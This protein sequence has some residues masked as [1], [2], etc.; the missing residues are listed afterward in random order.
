MENKITLKRKISQNVACLKYIINHKKK[1]FKTAW[2]RKQYIH[3]FTHDWDKLLPWRFVG[4]RRNFYPYTEKPSYEDSRAMIKQWQK[5]YR[6]NKHHW[7][8]W[9]VFNNC[10]DIRALDMPYKHIQQ[11]LADWEAIGKPVEYYF[12]NVTSM[13]FSNRT[14][15]VVDSEISKM[16]N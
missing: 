3:A 11:M 6:K 5:H 4:Y 9:V 15:Y 7:Q 16:E 12:H 2:K 8:Y 13:I 1:V 14:R 10:D